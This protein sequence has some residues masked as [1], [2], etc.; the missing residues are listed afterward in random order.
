MSGPLLDS[1]YDTNKDEMLRNCLNMSKIFNLAILGDGVIIA[2]V[3]LINILAASRNN[4]FAFLEII[5]C[6]D[7]MAKKGKKCARYLASLVRP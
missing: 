5:D 6:T 4:L 2:Y 1:L 7:Q 3:P